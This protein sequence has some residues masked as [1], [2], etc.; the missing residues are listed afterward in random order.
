MK[1]FSILLFFILTSC[2][3]SS[4][5][6]KEAP[7]SGDKSVLEQEIKATLTEMWD[8][9]EKG[10]ADRYSDYIHPHFTQFGEMDSVLRVGK[11]AEVNAIREFVSRAK[12]IHTEMIDPR[13]TINGNTAWVIY[14]WS[15]AGINRG[16]PFASRGKST[17]IFVRE[18]NKWLCIHGH[19]TLLPVQPN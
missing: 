15:D 14:Y 1:T 12:D 8:A 9:I 7:I 10:D 19:Y 5:E 6:T 13:V 4:T 18:N 2:S 17:R 11:E 16:K 3:N